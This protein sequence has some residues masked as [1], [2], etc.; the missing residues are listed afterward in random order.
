M[1]AQDRESRLSTGQVLLGLKILGPE[2]LS[3]ASSDTYI[4]G[5][6]SLRVAA[7][8]LISL[9]CLTYLTPTI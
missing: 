6:I 4:E 1:E 2:I 5:D 8:W 9:T 7:L 3:R